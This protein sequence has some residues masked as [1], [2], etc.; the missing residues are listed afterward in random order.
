ME[1]Y[2]EKKSTNVYTRTLNL[3]IKKIYPNPFFLLKDFGNDIASAIQT[4][5]M[6][7][8]FKCSTNNS[9]RVVRLSAI[10]C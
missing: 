10:V 1:K 8:Y 6:R 5:N 4:G 7:L 3:Y 2:L 9:A